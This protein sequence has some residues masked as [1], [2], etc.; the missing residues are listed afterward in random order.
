MRTINDFVREMPSERQAAVRNRAA[1]LIA[2]QKTLQQFRKMHLLTQKK[3]AS[4]LKID[5]ARVSKIEKGSDMLLSTL[6]GY[7][8][9]A[10]G[11]LNLTVKIGDGTI[12]LSVGELAGDVTAHQ[13]NTKRKAKTRTARIAA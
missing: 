3:I 8:E 13:E 11:T 9:A 6:R 1:T 2:E 4:R 7:V 5:Q 10:G 12:H